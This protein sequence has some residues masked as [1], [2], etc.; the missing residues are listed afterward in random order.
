MYRIRILFLIV[1]VLLTGCFKQETV[2]GIGEGEFWKAHVVYEV[3]DSN[4]Y[5]SGGIEYT[6]DEVLIYV[7]Y[8]VITGDGGSLNGE[9]YPQENQTAESFGTTI[10]N[11]PPTKDEAIISLNHSY[12]EIKWQ[13][14]TGEYEEKINLKVN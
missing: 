1:F 9:F 13:T 10:T 2:R 12:I 8:T 5:D 11:H 4:L 7:T 3:T 6:G 14:N